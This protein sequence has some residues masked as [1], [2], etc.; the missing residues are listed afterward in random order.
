[1]HPEL[2]QV[3]FIAAFSLILPLPW[4]WRAGNVA[5]L[6]IIGWLF[7]LDI[8]Y[9]I[10]VIIWAGNVDS[11]ATLW[12]DISTSSCYQH[13]LQLLTVKTAAKLIVGA[14]F[15]L[16][17][18][19]LCICIHLEQVASVRRG[20]VTIDDKRRRRIFECC[21]CL[22]LPVVFMAFRMSHQ[23]IVLFRLTCSQ[24]DYVVQG[25]RFDIVEDYGCRPTTYF[26]IPSIFIVWLPSILM[27]VGALIFAGPSS[28]HHVKQIFLILLTFRSCFE[29][30]YAEAP[31]FRDTP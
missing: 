18:A 13:C 25:H 8:I 26:S 12:C 5:T 29:T 9:A 7:V 30:F 21:M 23:H 16:P 6:S 4:H 19:C 15:A 1:M 24:L 22:G 10:D 11:V 2:A 17:A 28:K 14:N 20:G 3:A 27:A 31:H